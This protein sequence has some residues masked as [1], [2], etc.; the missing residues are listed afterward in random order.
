MT[1]PRPRREKKSDRLICP[2]ATSSEIACDYAI[3]PFDR[4]A[5]DMERRWGVDR[6]P[7]LVTPALAAKYGAAMAYL[8]DCINQ[9][10]AEGCA[11]AAANCIKG[12]AAMDAEARSL[13]HKPAP[14]EVWLYELDGHRFGIIRET[15]DWTTLQESHPGLTLYSLRE[16]AIALQS[17]KSALPKIEAIK[18]AFPGAEITA[19]RS[20]LAEELDDLIP[21]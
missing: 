13:G 3:A 17:Y 6:L 18:A 19:V 15:G 7:E 1:Q 2:G 9:G 5:L 8:N 4:V 11:A 14:A 20:K 21:F 16:V 12:L 10:D